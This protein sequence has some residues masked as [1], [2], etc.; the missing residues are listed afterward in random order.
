MAS[1]RILIVAPGADLGGS[2]AFALEAEG[3]D[4]TVASELP[5]HGSVA[6]FDCTVLDQKALT[7]ADHESIAFC[8]AAYPVVLLAARP[9]AWLLGWVAEV[10]ET[11]VI[12]NAMT[13]AVG[14]A[15]ATA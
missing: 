11:P 5:E 15:I 1:G 13:V 9:H 6:G 12:G 10:V 14:R 2:V 4:V 7:G 3:F 8:K